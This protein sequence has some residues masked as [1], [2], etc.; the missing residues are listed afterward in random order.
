MSLIP[1]FLE[2]S[3]SLRSPF[4]KNGRPTLVTSI[5][6]T[7]LPN[8]PLLKE[9]ILGKIGEQ[10]TGKTR[11]YLS[12][13]FAELSKLGIIKFTK[14][15]RTWSQGIRYHEYMGFIFMTMVTND[16]QA[17]TSLQYRLMPKRD[18]QSVDFIT[19]PDEDIFAKP[20]PYLTPKEKMQPLMDAIEESSI[21]EKKSKRTTADSYL[22]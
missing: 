10:H 2:N 6:A 14:R 17:V 20:N 19:S 1:T 7:L 9:T 8:K 4:D 5:L 22:S 12:N 18:E 21:V 16:E 11:G 13:H 3:K 15:D